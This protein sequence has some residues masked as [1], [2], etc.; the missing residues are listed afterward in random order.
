[1]SREQTTEEWVMELESMIH[2]SH[3]DLIRLV[4]QYRR[5]G[6]AVCQLLDD[7]WRRWGD[8]YNVASA[9]VISILDT[10]GKIVGYTKRDGKKARPLHCCDCCK[11][12]Q[13]GPGDDTVFCPGCRTKPVNLPWSERE[14]VKVLDRPPDVLTVEMSEH[15]IQIDSH[16]TG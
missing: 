2:L 14:K 4:L 9:E 12:Y 6:R 7:Q 1:V 11:E 15:R 13:C 8:V 16:F 5:M 3:S 10:L